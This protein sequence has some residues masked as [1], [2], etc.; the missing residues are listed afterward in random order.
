M[1]PRG[2]VAQREST[3]LTWRGSEVQSLSCPPL[4]AGKISPRAGSPCAK[5]IGVRRAADGR[6][7]NA[8]K[9]DW[10]LL[11]E[12]EWPEA[13]WPDPFMPLPCGCDRPIDEPVLLPEVPDW[14]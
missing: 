7:G 3:A 13:E 2:H 5:K 10:T 12:V 6:L 11:P 8:D 9:Y 14:F 1:A 4:P